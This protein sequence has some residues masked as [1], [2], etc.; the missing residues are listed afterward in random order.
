[1]WEGVLSEEGCV[2]CGVLYEVRAGVCCMG[3]CAVACVG[4][5]VSA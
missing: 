3:S 4:A 2:E 1:M 5:C